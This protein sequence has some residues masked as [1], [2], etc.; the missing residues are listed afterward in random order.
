MKK[1]LSILLA[2]CL[3]TSLCTIAISTASAETVDASE[4]KTT[5]ETLLDLDFNGN[6]SAGIAAT[7]FGTQYNNFVKDGVMTV[8]QGGNGGASL[9]FGANESINADKTTIPTLDTSYTDASLT[10]ELLENHFTLEPDTTFKRST[11][12]LYGKKAITTAEY[13]FILFCIKSFYRF[14]QV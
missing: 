7:S 2:M 8:V 1:I 5:Y 12:S 6:N 13:Y 3:L 9:W 14:C 10:T 4:Q 11:V